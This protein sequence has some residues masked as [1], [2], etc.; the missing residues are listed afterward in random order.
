MAVINTVV[1]KSHDIKDAA[2]NLNA[3]AFELRRTLAAV[4]DLK[5]TGTS[6]PPPQESFSLDMKNEGGES[7]VGEGDERTRVGDSALAPGGKYRSIVKLFIRYEFQKPG[8]WAM[9]TGWLVRP[10]VLVTAG[11]CS[12]DW[13]HKL[14]RAVEIKAYIGYKGHQSENDPNVQ[15]RSVSRIVTTEGWVKTKGQKAFD[16][17]F[18]QVNKPFTGIKPFQFAE[19]P[20]SGDLVIGV[21]G[22][23][24]DLSDKRTGEKG[25]YMYEMFLPTQYDLTA[26]KDTMLEYQIDTFGGNSGS[27][28]LRQDDFVSIGAHVYGGEVNS[29]SVIGKF[30]NPYVDYLAA[31]GLPLS[32]EGLN[33]VPVTGNPEI[34][35]PVPT[36]LKG[37]SLGQ[38]LCEVCQSRPAVAPRG[39][40][41][42]QA[43]AAQSYGAAAQS[44]PAYGNRSASHKQLQSVLRAAPTIKTRYPVRLPE[45]D[46][47]GFIDVL[48]K[49]A[50][51]G[52]PLIGKALNVALPFALGPIGAP[53]G[54]LAGFA[55]N[56]AGKLASPESMMGAESVID[57][58]TL[59]E[60]S[61]E[62]AV[63]AEAVLTTIQSVELSHEAEEGI[64]SD[65]KDTVMKALPTI[66]KAAPHVLGAMME[67][68]LR[69]ALDSLH[70][71]NAKLSTGGAESFDA[72]PSSDQQEPLP[73]L[74]YSAAIDQPAD[75]NAE[76][77]LS[78]LQSSMAATQE[79]SLL[80][81]DEAEEG[82]F[83]II[84]AGARFAG[85]GLSAVAKHGLP[86]L[87]KALEGSGGAE[88]TLD[89][90]PATNQPHAFSADALAHRAIVAEAALQA[91]MKVPPQQLQEEGIFDFIAQAVKK[92]A[93]VAM[94]MA[95]MVAGAINPTV[96]KIV[97]GLMGQESA[98]A[99]GGG[100]DRYGEYGP[101]VGGG[102]GYGG[103]GHRAG[104]GQSNGRPR[105]GGRRS[106][107]DLR[108][109]AAASGTGMSSYSTLYYQNRQNGGGT[110][111]LESY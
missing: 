98:M 27:P 42:A 51:V 30:G 44:R 81:G 40:S 28:V 92:I 48:R 67:P 50:S 24:G 87:V 14:G 17:S 111:G 36:G 13:S 55:L 46:E 72:L 86:L 76:A 105:L 94:K 33:L 45:T 11:H 79:S 16:V 97:G 4:W 80:D 106:L 103:Y 43:P 102:D 109:G 93:P 18:M 5:P 108:K 37:S 41:I 62:R 75:R 54:A 89:N 82:F 52:A 15:F 32:N 3:K 104:G 110:H 77:F 34:S 9:G 49:A 19:T 20:A 107:A 99:Q 58:Q 6:P 100:A 53:V 29:A 83:D 22:Y 35:A 71:H 74:L 23:P 66:R 91:V 7:V 101:R 10:D 8:S 2:L 96:G 57:G 73:K 69:I 60:G 39:R 65:M 78:T 59:P 64:F 61:L 21:V 47:E 84:K 25:A 63:L 88:S 31:F 38:S 12:Y 1:S 90:G 70:A 26:Q 68:A 56:A 95:P 85:Q